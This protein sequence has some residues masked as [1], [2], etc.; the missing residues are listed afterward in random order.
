MSDKNEGTQ[1][2]AVMIFVIMMLCIACFIASFIMTI[3]FAYMPKLTYPDPIFNVEE[4]GDSYGFDLRCDI[5]GN[6]RNLDEIV[7]QCNASGWITQ[8]G[9]G[10]AYTYLYRP[11]SYGRMECPSGYLA[12]I[13]STKNTSVSWI[14]LA[15]S[16]MLISTLI[17]AIPTFCL[18][19]TC[20]SNKSLPFF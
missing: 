3:L 14:G 10:A 9:C 15:F 6:T 18:L 13:T 5:G 11:F 20:C 2:W 17:F 4:T 16:M 7:M 1:C 12:E 19:S 8:P